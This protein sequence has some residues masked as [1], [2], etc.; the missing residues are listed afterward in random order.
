M[1]NYVNLCLL[2]HFQ[3]EETLNIDSSTQP[4]NQITAIKWHPKVRLL[5]LGYETGELVIWN[6]E[7]G[8]A[9][10]GVCKNIANLNYS[11][12]FFINKGTRSHNAS[13][14]L[15]EWSHDGALLV[16]SDNMGILIIWKSD[17]QGHLQTHFI[18]DFKDPVCHIV[19]RQ[20]AQPSEKTR[21]VV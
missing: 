9:F 13:I 21:W 2:P 19:F 17:S 20:Q 3:K 1:K 6:H 18:H 15:M 12:R 14:V 5:A 7:E 16:S 8:E 4:D 10:E 11:L